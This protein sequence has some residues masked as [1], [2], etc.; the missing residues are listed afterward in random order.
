L[1]D[2]ERHVGGVASHP[3]P[4]RCGKPGGVGLDRGQGPFYSS[5]NYGQRI[6]GD[7]EL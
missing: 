3:H 2:A 4:G 6:A 5:L 1:H 7:T